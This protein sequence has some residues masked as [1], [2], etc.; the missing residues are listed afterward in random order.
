VAKRKKIVLV[1]FLLLLNLFLRAQSD[2]ITQRIVLIGDAGELTNGQHPVVDAVRKYITLDNKTTILYLGD[3][4]YKNGLPD[5]QFKASFDAARAV[6][7]SQMSIADGTAAKVYMIPGNHDWENGSKG[8]Y[9]AV[10]REQL[11]V[12]FLGKGDTV[13]YY[14][15]DGCPGPDVVPL[16]NNVIIIMFDSQWWLHPYD[17]PGIESDCK[18]RSGISL[19][20]MQKNLS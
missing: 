1:G 8:G 16:G 13:T 7:D 11:Y 4:L 10:I 6:L 2:T 15:K 14:P 5:K 17:K 12:E 3:N 20:K 19:P 9:D 18:T